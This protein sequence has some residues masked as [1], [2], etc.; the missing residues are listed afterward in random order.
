MSV[1]ERLQSEVQALTENKLIELF[2]KELNK[3]KLDK[4][5]HFEL[6]ARIAKETFSA[7][8]ASWESISKK[9]DKNRYKAYRFFAGAEDAE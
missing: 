1:E 8:I 6:F 4:G 9:S 3:T 7:L 5:E 2:S